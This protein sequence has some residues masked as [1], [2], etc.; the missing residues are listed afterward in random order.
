M[1]DNSKTVP[2]Q[3][4]AK[5]GKVFHVVLDPTAEDNLQYIIDFAV[6][7]MGI[8]PSKAVVVRTALMRYRNYLKQKFDNPNDN[9]LDR[10]VNIKVEKN[11][12][13]AGAGKAKLYSV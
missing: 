8:N 13:I 11:A 2:L 7:N 1:N 9:G 6:N 12:L 10:Q 5:D 3:A 4:T